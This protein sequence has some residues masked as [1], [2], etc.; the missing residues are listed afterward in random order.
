MLS[1]YWCFLW[2]GTQA[3]TMKTLMVH[4]RIKMHEKKEKAHTQACT[5]RTGKSQNK[6]R[7]G[8]HLADQPWCSY[9]EVAL[10]QI[11]TRIGLRSSQSVELLQGAS[12]LVFLIPCLALAPL[13]I[14]LAQVDRCVWWWQP[15]FIPR[16]FG[17]NGGRFC[18]LLLLLRFAALGF[19]STSMAD[20]P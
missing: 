14:F 9:C 1:A 10:L 7:F 8:G 16:H 5:N 17:G 15:A 4:E 2:N 12:S 19:A 13:W 18:L 6:R 20:A 11:V 3:H